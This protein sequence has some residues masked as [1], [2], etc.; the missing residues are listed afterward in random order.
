MALIDVGAG[1]TNRASYYGGSFTRVNVS[2]PANATGTLT[3]I[4][5]YVD[6]ELAGTIKVATFSPDGTKLTPRDVVTLGTVAVGLQTVTED[7][8]SDP[9]ALSVESGDLI[10]M[11]WD[12][13]G[14]RVSRDDTGGDGVYLK[15]GDQTEAGEQTYTLLP[16]N[17]ISLYATGETAPS[18]SI[19][20][21]MG[22]PIA[23]VKTING[24]PIADVKSFLGV[25]NV[26]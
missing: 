11:Y 4:Q 14:D 25:S 9:I 2:N 3:S 15:S 12:S 22:V 13:T 5:I 1:A 21:V 17:A 6:I 18:T 20:L 16:G 10:G 26:S 8:S 23:N 24:V 19:K 7:A